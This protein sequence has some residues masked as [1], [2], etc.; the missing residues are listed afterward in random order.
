M[1][2]ISRRA[3]LAGVGAAIAG[4]AVSP[5]RQADAAR[6]PGPT[7]DQFVRP[8]DSRYPQLTTGNN[9]RFVA[10]PEYFRMVR[11]TSDAERALRQAVDA[12]RRVSVRSGGHRFA[13]PVCNSGGQGLLRPS[14]VKPG[15]YQ[16][17][18]RAVVGQPGGG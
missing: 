12:G 10:R 13:A 4:T 3:M 6:E 17:G 11:S 9:P 2:Q 15:D 1:G 16:P 5:G 14:G 8:D 18:G 7:P